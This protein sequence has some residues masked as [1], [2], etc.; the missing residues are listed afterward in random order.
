MKRW[1]PLALAVVAAACGQVT[2]SAPPGS[3]SP[4]FGPTGSGSA[5]PPTVLPDPKHEVYGF[6]P[7]WEMDDTIADHVG[8]T[9]LTTL[10]LFSVTHKRN[11]TLDEQ[12]GLK[13][14]RGGVGQ[15]MIRAAHDRGTRV[16]IVYTSF[17][18]AKNR[19]FYDEP[20]A[21]DRWIDEIVGLVEEAGVDGINVDVEALPFDLVPQ[22]GAFV[23]RLREALRE[24]LPDAQVSVATQANEVGA[25]MAR[26]AA[27]AGVER[28]FL[29]GYDYRVA[30]SQPGASA[31]IDRMDGEVKDLV[32]SLD[33]YATLGVPSDRLLLGLPLYGVTWPVIAP[34]FLAPSSGR[35]DA[36]VPRRNLGVFHDPAFAPIYDATESVEFYSVPTAYATP[37]PSASVPGVPASA[38]PEP[39]AW[40]AVYYDSPRSLTPKLRLA[41]DR[42]LAGAGFWAI[43][44]ERGLPGYTELIATFRSGKLPRE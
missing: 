25:A 11:G 39:I 44:Y 31:P 8:A 36:W 30:G 20:K 9:D 43:G 28:I 14:I 37:E 38:S 16:E 3:G 17:G 21:Q 5:A 41:D 23:G 2:P 22:Y 40:D 18:E 19:Q 13:R 12:T 26:A 27:D 42:G 29:M 10:G 15:A 32:W 35:G 4:A 33:L 34:G 6:V 1:L 7:Y 24:R